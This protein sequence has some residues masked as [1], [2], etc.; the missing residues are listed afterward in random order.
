MALSY[1]CDTFCDI[2]SDFVEGEGTQ[3]GN[4]DGLGRSALELAKLAGWKRRRTAAGTYEDVC[5]RCLEKETN[6]S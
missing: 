4:A 2:C 3:H 6:K 1:Q 5:K